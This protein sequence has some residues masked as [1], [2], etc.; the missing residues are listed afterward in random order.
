MRHE[1]AEEVEGKLH[2]EADEEEGK[3]GVLCVLQSG[4][5]FRG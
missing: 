1:E 5:S 4:V 2:D 3:L